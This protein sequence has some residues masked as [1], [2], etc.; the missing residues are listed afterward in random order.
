MFK[1]I[2]SLVAIAAFAATAACGERQDETYVDET[3]VVTPEATETAPVVTPPAEET[4][5]VEEDTVPLT[6]AEETD[7]ETM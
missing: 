4:V 5:I 1:K 3:T 2:T 6:E 7:T